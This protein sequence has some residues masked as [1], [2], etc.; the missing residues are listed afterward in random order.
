MVGDAV[1]QGRG[2]FG[3]AEHGRPFAEREVRSDDDPGTLLKLADEVEQQ[4]SS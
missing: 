2:H 3:V 4:L 1:E